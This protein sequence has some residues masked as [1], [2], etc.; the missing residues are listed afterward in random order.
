MPV[1]PPTDHSATSFPSSLGADRGTVL[2][3]ISGS[4]R[5]GSLNTALL[6]SAQDL[7]VA[8]VA[9]ELHPLHEVPLYDGDVEARGF[10]PAVERF[11]SAIA[12][13]DGL[14][15]A[16]PEYNHSISGVLKNAIDWAS[17]GPAAPLD[18]MP[19][20]LLSAAGGSGGRRAQRHLREVLAH[21]DVQVI[22]RSLQV[23]RA[24]DHVRDGRLVTA[25]HRATLQAV[26][27]E[28]RDHVRVR[29][30]ASVR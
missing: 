9:L 28:L 27:T 16:A 8:G 4:L 26:L 3:G 24:R 19:T 17:R 5:R 25:E 23:P 13:A 20:A 14:V 6:R 12:A 22:D 21:N 11:R 2:L 18:G 30:A 15:L 10:P 29:E 7:A 1:E